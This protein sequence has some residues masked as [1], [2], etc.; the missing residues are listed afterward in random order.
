MFKGKGFVKCLECGKVKKYRKDRF[1]VE[2][3]TEDGEFKGYWCYDCVYHEELDDM[4]NDSWT[5]DIA[6]SNKGRKEKVN[7]N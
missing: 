1:P 4:K 3:Y 6:H 5:D 7:D 2:I